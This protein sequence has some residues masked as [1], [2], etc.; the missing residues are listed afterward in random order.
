MKYLS[1]LLGIFLL[2]FSACRPTPTAPQ[3]SFNTNMGASFDDYFIDYVPLKETNDQDISYIHPSRKLIAFTFDDGPSKTMESLLALFASFNESHPDCKATA[4][5]FCNGL[6][7][8]EDALPTLY[9]ALAMGM[10]L[11][12]HTFSHYD[13]TTLPSEKLRE[14]IEQTETLLRRVDGRA[15]HLLRPPYGRIND[16]LRRATNAP[17]IHWTIDTLDWTGA[18]ADDIYNS[19]WKDR[20]SGAI[21]L[22]HDGYE[23]TVSALKRLLP[24]LAADGYQAVCVSDMAKAHGVTFKNG[25]VYI[26]ARKQKKESA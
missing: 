1:F 8:R 5:F 4:T 25:S 15:S 11:G 23:H 7:I 3:S 12:N 21:V 22:M 14:E 19:V 20:F 26:R 6:H 18:S 17:I 9:A 2:L 16:E 24:D 13:L 10:E